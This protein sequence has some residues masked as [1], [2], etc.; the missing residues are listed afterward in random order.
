M[1]NHQMTEVVQQL[2]RSVIRDGTEPT[3]GQLLESFIHRRDEAALE[4]LVC[5]H[6]AMVWGVCRRGLQRHQDAED[7][8]QATFLVLVRKAASIKPRAMVGNWLYGVAH[9]TALKARATTMKRQAR[10]KQVK[11]T[12]EPIAPE[13]DLCSD[14]RPLLDQELSLLPDKY[15]VALILCDLEGKTRKEAAG[16]L[17]LPEGTLAS[18]LARARTMLAKRLAQRGLVVSGGTLAGYLSEQAASAAVPSA[19]LACTIKAVSLVAAGT[20]GPISANVALLMQGVLHGMMLT[21]LKS[22]TA[23]TLL[24]LGMIGFGGGFVSEKPK[25]GQQ[26]TAQTESATPQQAVRTEVVPGADVERTSVSVLGVG[27]PKKEVAQGDN[28]RI[29][30]TWNL[31]T[32]KRS[33]EPYADAKMVS[34]LVDYLNDNAQR[35]NS[36]RFSDLDMTWTV[37]GSSFGMR[38]LMSAQ[39]PRHFRMTGALLGSPCLDIGSNDKEFW[40]WVSKGK[41]QFYCSYQDLADN[42]A[43]T[44][45]IPFH[46]DWIM[47]VVMGFGNYGP[48]ER[49]RL[50][51][52][53][54][55]LK[56]VES[57]RDVAGRPIRREIILERSEV[58]SPAPQVLAHVL[59]DGASGQEIAAAHVRQTQL[60]RTTGAIWPRRLELRWA[61]DNQPM[62]LDI[63]LSESTINERFARALFERPL[64]QGVSSFN[65]ARPD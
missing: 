2:R 11:G 32:L 25:A 52:E 13:Q 18:R 57:T 1:A 15:R 45:P 42:R 17:S 22:M 14:L 48:P 3:D 12:P 38:G 47:E 50:E 7:A 58:K 33:K 64:L 40:Y 59:L 26:G 35:M 6:A 63:K 20:V 53:A 36:I 46:P 31:V 51:T 16:Q 19:V 23:V 37:L 65:L 61:L 49:Y 24:A 29:Q 62:K 43:Q 8:F 39:K 10:E 21:S 60:D 30:G 27:A 55:T 56:L 28:E 4:V 44:L 9:Q 5:R 54:D 41:H 34:A